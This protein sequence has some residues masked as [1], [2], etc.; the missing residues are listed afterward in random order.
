MDRTDNIP[1][2]LHAPGNVNGLSN[3][4]GVF[5]VNLDEM[6][7]FS[8][9]A[10]NANGFPTV[11]WASRPISL[12]DDAS[13][14]Q[15]YGYSSILV[16]DINSE[17]RL[18]FRRSMPGSL[19]SQDS[20]GIRD[21]DY[22]H[23][24]DWLSAV[25]QDALASANFH[26]GVPRGSF[27]M[28]LGQHSQEDSESFVG[29]IRFSYSSPTLA[30]DTTILA[31]NETYTARPVVVYN[32]QETACATINIRVLEQQGD[33]SWV[34]EFATNQVMSPRRNFD[35]Y[36]CRIPQNLVDGHFK[37]EITPVM[38]D[39]TTSFSLADTDDIEFD[40]A[41]S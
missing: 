34:E 14:P 31:V 10:D 23:I 40:V 33:L 2:N 26:R 15:S 20:P 8:S 7:D 36:R 39:G 29:A 4:M 21:R 11:H 35:E 22:M 17:G 19:Y 24:G 3:W 13:K 41:I 18:S 28:Q 6:G 38:N 9:I 30:S 37:V 27:D 5:G 16:S 1:L 12:A 25:Q 32:T